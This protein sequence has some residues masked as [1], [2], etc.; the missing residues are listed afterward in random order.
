MVH[1]TIDTDRDSLET[2][3]HVISLLQK[4]LG[5]RSSNGA[6][7]LIDDMG[8]ETSQQPVEMQTQE[9]SYAPEPT[10]AVLPSSEPQSSEIQA[11][12]FAM[13]G[14]MGGSNEP[15][16]P[17]PEPEPTS[18]YDTSGAIPMV[19]SINSKPRQ[20]QGIVNLDG[21]QGRAAPKDCEDS[22]LFAKQVKT[23]MQRDEPKKPSTPFYDLEF[24]D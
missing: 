6:Q 15:S 4:E 22:A 14:D 20:S 10:S 2:I 5:K 11:N 18:V 13:F 19:T 16:T 17:A 1:I 12:P 24:Y 21:L 9:S 23:G 7:A 8:D 3:Q